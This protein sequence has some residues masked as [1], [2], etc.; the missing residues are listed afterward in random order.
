MNRKKKVRSLNN[1]NVINF[2]TKKNIDESPLNPPEFDWE[3]EVHKDVVDLVQILLYAL[4]VDKKI[5][6]PDQY[7]PNEEQF[8]RD[9]ALI[10]VGLKS[11][12]EHHYGV[13]PTATTQWVESIQERLYRFKN[14]SGLN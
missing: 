5:T 12:L 10:S 7:D 6:V 14:D 8:T 1:E 4:R 11:L 2:F 13:G 3:E 9:M